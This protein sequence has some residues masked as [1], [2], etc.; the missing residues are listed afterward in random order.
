MFQQQQPAFST[1]NMDVIPDKK[2]LSSIDSHQPKFD[3]DVL[4][5]LLK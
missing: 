2:Y 1:L 5:E 4:R 3:P